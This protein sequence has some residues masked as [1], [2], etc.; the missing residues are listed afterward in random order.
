[1]E[2]TTLLIIGGSSTALEIRECAELNSDEYAEILNVVGDNEDCQYSFIQDHEL[3][4]KLNTTPNCRFIVGFT[5]VELKEK[6]ESIFASHN[7]EPINV[8]HPTAIIS[9]SAKLGKGNYVGAYVTISSN[10]IVGNNNLINLQV[11]I[12]HDSVTGNNCAINPAARVS[13]H[14]KIGDNCL[15]GA[16]TF[17]Y[18]GA[19]ICHDTQIDAMVYIRENVKEPS[20]IFSKYGSKLLT[21]KRKRY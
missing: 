19:S 6:Y 10:A 4:E 13:G 7:F 1:M 3:E 5:N 9:P 15:I 21:L 14:V 20:V 17:I 18:Q 2:K 11:T 12:G 16:N 8:I